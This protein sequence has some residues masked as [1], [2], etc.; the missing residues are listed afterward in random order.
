MCLENAGAGAGD[1][2]GVQFVV[3][4]GLFNRYDDHF[5][6]ATSSCVDAYRYA[7]IRRLVRLGCGLYRGSVAEKQRLGLVARFV[8]GA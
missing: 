1:G 4:R 2:V 3:F 6:K 8:L 7:R 5:L